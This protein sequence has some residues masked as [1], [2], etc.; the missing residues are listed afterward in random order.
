[1]PPQPPNPVEVFY[2]YA[3]E[4]EK[5]R[6]E[7][8][9]HLVNLKRQGIITDWYDRDINAGNEWDDE[10]KKHIDT[11][12]V[13]LLLISPDFM[14]SD[15]C[16]D[17][18]VK[19]AMERHDAGEACVI[20][21]F[22]RPVNW[23]GALFGKLQ[24]LPTDAKPVTMWTN[25]DEAFVIVSEGIQRAVEA[26]NA[27]RQTGEATTAGKRRASAHIPRPPIVGF[28]ARRDEQGRDIVERLKVELAPQ[29]NPLVTL[30]GPG[31]VGKTTLA[32][33]AARALQAEFGERIVWSR[34]EGRADFSLSTL[35][36]DIS[37]QLGRED[38]RTL[39][40][41]LK[42]AQVHAL[43]ADSPALIVLDNYET[44][45]LEAKK[46]IQEWFAPAQCSTL[47]TSRHPINSTRNI[48][49]AAMSR[50]EAQDYMER[51]ILQ[52]QD[53]QIFSTAVRQRIYETAEANPYVMQWVE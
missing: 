16:N 25:H 53:A 52:T 43:V 8:K 28:V 32:A 9:K 33:E 7:L 48:S 4:D 1:V 24:G 12:S 26:L 11:A 34:A 42:E 10:I 19:R 50:E 15:Y 40:P 13:I 46:S 35:L 38:L 29:G 47:F 27:K 3:H 31:G 17:V 36:D 51:L 22:L 18:E 49:I 37:T 20:P 5:L 39:A 30:S 23:K 14:N 44:I 2:S 6:D 45:A 21:V 41:Q